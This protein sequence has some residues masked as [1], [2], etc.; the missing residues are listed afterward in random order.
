MRVMARKLRVGAAQIGGIDAEESREH[1]IER[2]IALLEKAAGRGVEL[3]VYPECSLTTYFPRFLI[4]D[5]EINQYFEKAMP[6]PSVQPLFDKAKEYGIAFYLGYSELENGKRFNSSVLV[7]KDGKIIGKYQKSHIGGT[8]EPVID[9]ESQYMERRYFQPGDTGFKVWSALGGQ[10]GMGICYDR[11]FPEFWRVMGMKGAELVLLGFLSGGRRGGGSY[12][13]VLHHLLCIQAGAY[14]NGLWIIAS[15]HCGMGH[16]AIVSPTGEIVVKS[17]TNKDELIDATIDLDTSKE[18]PF[19]SPRA[20]TTNCNFVRD[21]RPDLYGILSD[22][23][24]GRNI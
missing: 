18:N 6:N 14:W 2:L 10:V 7:G 22:E 16:S 13:G 8:I 17:Y 11:R 4:P 9:R 21:R 1:I 19:F 3:V 15:A 24:W 5:S 12:L 20:N 23:K